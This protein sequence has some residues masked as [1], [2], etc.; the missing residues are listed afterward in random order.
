MAAVKDE[1]N[2]ARDGVVKEVEEV[3]ETPVKQ[4]QVDPNFVS[5]LDSSTVLTAV[6]VSKSHAESM[7]KRGPNDRLTRRLKLCFY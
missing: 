2:D 5:K 4:K 6:E 3:K 7:R 1:E